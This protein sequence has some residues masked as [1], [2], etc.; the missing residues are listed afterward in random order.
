LTDLNDKA[1]AHADIKQFAAQRGHNLSDEE[2]ESV[3]DQF[4]ALYMENIEYDGEDGLAINFFWQTTVPVS[5]KTAKRIRK[6]SDKLS[7]E[8]MIQAW[9][10]RVS[11]SPPSAFDPESEGGNL[12]DLQEKRTELNFD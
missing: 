12:D 6:L 9:R 7:R 2:A 10:N 11:E 8:E 5:R 1:A 3:L 4:V